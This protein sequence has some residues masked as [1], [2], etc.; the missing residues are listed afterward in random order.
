MG[1]L[2]KDVNSTEDNPWD[3]NAKGY[4][5]HVREGGEIFF[6]NCHF[7]HGDNLNGRGLW[8]FAFN[9]IPANFTDA[10]TIAQLQETF[11][12]WRVAKG[13]IG[14]PGEGFP[15]ASVMPPWEQHL[16]ATTRGPGIKEGRE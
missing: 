13:G 11:V 15:W 10:G 16:T 6:Q 9:P 5:K 1:R 12:F 7:C 4:I 2:M 8:A 3:P 14:L